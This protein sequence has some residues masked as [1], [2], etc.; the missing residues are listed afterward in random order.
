MSGSSRITRAGGP[1]RSR[2]S[3]SSTTGNGL[4]GD[5]GRR[6]TCAA[7]PP[8][9]LSRLPGEQPAE[10][11]R[12]LRALLCPDPPRRLPHARLLN[13]TAR[14]IHLGAF[15][16]LLG[17]HV[18][19]VDAER[20]LPAFWVTVLSGLALVALE[21]AASLRWVVE[22]RGVAVF[23]KLGLLLLIPV[24]WEY[25][26]PLLLGVVVIASIGSHMPARFRHPPVYAFLARG[27]GAARGARDAR[28][29]RDAKEAEDARGLRGLRG[30]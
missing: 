22:G 3:G 11:R 21:C 1:D 23:L 2:R 20:L 18:W 9:A 12:S 10:A 29:A 17:G 15:G 28:D 6:E 13:I 8:A 7:P 5:G 14:T 30:R 4:V 16:L 27:R 24:W 25:R 26:V 19:A